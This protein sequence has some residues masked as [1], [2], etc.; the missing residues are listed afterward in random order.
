[1][2]NG[3]WSCQMRDT[4][5]RTPCRWQPCRW[6]RA[7]VPPRW[8]HIWHARERAHDSGWVGSL[9]RDL[10]HFCKFGCP[11]CTQ[12]CRSRPESFRH[13][14][15]QHAQHRS[16]CCFVS[17]NQDALISLII[18]IALQEIYQVGPQRWNEILTLARLPAFRGAAKP[19]HIVGLIHLNPFDPYVNGHVLTYLQHLQPLP[20]C[21][22]KTFAKAH[23]VLWESRLYSTKTIDYAISA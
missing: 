12:S 13:I 9:L 5:T 10:A 21:D 3:G 6:C 20:H 22:P 15:L 14:E 19:A 11:R 1:M 8:S 7:A 17:R 23:S 2:C 4:V 16:T 18:L